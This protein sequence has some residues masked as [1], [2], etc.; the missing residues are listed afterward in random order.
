[1]VPQTIER[2]IM[3]TFARVFLDIP[4]GFLYCPVP[5]RFEFLEK[6]AWWTDP[7]QRRFVIKEMLKLVGYRVILS[8]PAGAVWR[9]ML[10]KERAG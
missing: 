9:L 3:M 2:Q 8:A 10:L 6:E 5:P 1:M 7:D 4:V